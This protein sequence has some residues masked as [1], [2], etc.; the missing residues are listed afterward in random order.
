MLKIYLGPQKADY[1]FITLQA[2]NW[3]TLFSI[4]ING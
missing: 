4:K 1:I 2:Y 3:A